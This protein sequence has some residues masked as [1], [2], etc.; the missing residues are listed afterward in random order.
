MGV[1][2][3]YLHLPSNS[4]LDKFPQ[5]VGDVFVPSLRFV[6]VEG[7][8]GQRINKSILRP[9][10]IPVDKKV[11]ETIDVNI[12]RDTGESALFESGKVMLTLHFRESKLACLSSC[13]RQLFSCSLCLDGRTF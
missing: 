3:F 1:T 5:Y 7:L 9:Q 6:P 2:Q 12:R 11:F 8:D 10:Y 13:L 4:N